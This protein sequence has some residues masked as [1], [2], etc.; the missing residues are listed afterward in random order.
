MGRKQKVKVLLEPRQR[1]S[2][3]EDK[4]GTAR[5]RLV[6]VVCAP[7]NRTQVKHRKAC[8]SWVSEPPVVTPEVCWSTACIG[9]GFVRSFLT[10]TRGDLSASR[11]RPL[12]IAKNERTRR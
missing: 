2:N 9:D 5:D 8:K 4:G 7:R 12:V 6:E 1:E 10:L 11:G 3:T